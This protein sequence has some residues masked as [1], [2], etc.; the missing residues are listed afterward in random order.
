[1]STWIEKADYLRNLINPKMT[2]RDN[3]VITKCILLYV[4]CKYIFSR[5]MN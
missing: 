3:K 1:M 2:K 5:N 4:V